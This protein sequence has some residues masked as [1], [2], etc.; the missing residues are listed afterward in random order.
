MERPTDLDKYKKW[1]EEELGYRGIDG[2]VKRRYE[3]VSLLVRSEFEQTD[4]W[5]CLRKELEE[6]EAAYKM[7]KMDTHF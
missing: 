7:K 3:S 1:L 2:K 5:K 6:S 4:F